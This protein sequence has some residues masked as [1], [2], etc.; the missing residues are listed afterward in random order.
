MRAWV[1]NV[2]FSSCEKHGYY[3]M[4]QTNVA[5][6]ICGTNDETNDESNMLFETVGFT[7]LLVNMMLEPLVLAALCLEMLK[8]ILF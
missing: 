8:V 3:N 6:H 7:T 1:P 5:K 4:L 2:E